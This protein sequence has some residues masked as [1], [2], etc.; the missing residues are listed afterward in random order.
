MTITKE[1]AEQL[2]IEM[3]ELLKKTYTQLINEVGLI[4][5]KYDGVDQEEMI[6]TLVNA[7]TMGL[8]ELRKMNEKFWR[9]N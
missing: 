6:K 5:I 1:E 7:K 4:L 9:E 8:E 2:M 3:S